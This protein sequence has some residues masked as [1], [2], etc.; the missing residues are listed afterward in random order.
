VPAVHTSFLVQ[1][2][3]SLQLVPSPWL[4]QLVVA[5]AG[6]QTLQAFAELLAPFA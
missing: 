3:P 6:L 1:A 5:C 4:L 2:L